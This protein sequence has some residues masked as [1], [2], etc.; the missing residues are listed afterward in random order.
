MKTIINPSIKFHIHFYIGIGIFCMGILGCKKNNSMPLTTIL[1]FSPSHGFIGDTVIIMGSNFS[2][3][4]SVYFNGTPV[5]TIVS[6]TNTH[7]EVIVPQGAT[8]GNIKIKQGKSTV[9]SSS[10]FTVDPSVYVCG[11]DGDNACYWKN[12]KETILSKGSARSVY[13]LDNDIYIAGYIDNGKHTVAC[14]WKNDTLVYLSDG[15]G[16]ALANAIC[17]S[18]NDVYVAGYGGNGNYPMACYWKNGTA[19]YLTDGTDYAAISSIYVSGNSVYTAGVE[20]AL[21][22]FDK[23]KYWKNSKEEELSITNNISSSASSVYVSGNDVYIAGDDG[24]SAVYWENGKETVLNGN[25]MGKYVCSSGSD[26]YIAGEVYDATSSNG[27]AVYWKNG[28]AIYLTDSKI[29]A[30]ANAICIT[31]GDVYTVGDYTTGYKSV[32]VYWKNGTIITLPA[33]SDSYSYAT[34]IFVE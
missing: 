3:A 13:V 26:V 7:L 18:D 27:L 29:S 33:Q 25:G 9:I 19:I 32:S 34:A 22:G 31:A 14:Y 23:A 10:V 6:A 21:N 15:S 8:S 24:N 30:S 17:I 12:G 16:D 11:E 4:D 2:S 1:S 5:K 20:T 28:T